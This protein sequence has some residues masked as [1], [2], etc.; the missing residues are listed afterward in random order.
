[1]QYESNFLRIP[2]QAVEALAKVNLSK[3][4]IKILWVILRETYG[5]NR[6]YDIIP[7]STFIKKTGLKKSAISKARRKLILRGIIKAVKDCYGHYLI[8]E[9]NEDFTKWRP[10]DKERA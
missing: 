10:L 5:N 4:E 7:L 2:N 3:S 9:F 6:K 8:Y 1:M